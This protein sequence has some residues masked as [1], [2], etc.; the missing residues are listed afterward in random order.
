MTV[1][2]TR[3]LSATLLALAVAILFGPLLWRLYTN[4]ASRRAASA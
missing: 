2:V 4:R 1:F 3:P